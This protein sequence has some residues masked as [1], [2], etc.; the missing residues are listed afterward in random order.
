MSIKIG[1][2]ICNPKRIAKT[3]KK[4]GK[5]F[6]KRI[7]TEREMKLALEAKKL[8]MF[9]LAGR[10]AIKEAVSKVLGTGIGKGVAFKDIEVIRGDAG[11]PELTLHGEAKK[12][13][14]E[15]GFKSWSVTVSHEK[16][17]VVAIAVA[18]TSSD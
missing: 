12:K 17:M 18:S 10:Y 2:D 14:E 11:Q 5:K 16:T 4:F 3:Y 8:F 1:T 6:L 9:R 13:S 7:L 15:L